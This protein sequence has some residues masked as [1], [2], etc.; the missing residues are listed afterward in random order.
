MELLYATG[1][2]VVKGN[3]ASEFT[4]DLYNQTT[5]KAYE[6]YLDN[7]LFTSACNTEA[8]SDY[9]KLQNAFKSGR[10][11]FYDDLMQE[12]YK[13][14][15]LDFGILPW[16]KYDENVQGYPTTLGSYSNFFIVP[17]TVKDAEMVSVVL[18]AMSFYGYQHIISVYF[19]DVLSYKYS[20]DPE[21][22]EVLN[23]IKDSRIYDL[24]GAYN[25]GGIGDM[26]KLLYEA[27]TADAMT[28][29]Y[30]SLSGIATETFK[31]WSKIK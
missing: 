15:K 4:L 2:R 8:P 3:S 20:P 16:P 28:Q 14:D 18:E 29:L 7:F 26:G 5:V 9:G 30:T 19:D 11:V 24:S 12:V 13:F 6:D 1:H 17:K 22:V 31:D 10:V 25:F 23:L 21:S 27:E